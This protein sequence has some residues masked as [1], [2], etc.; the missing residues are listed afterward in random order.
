MAADG[1]GAVLDLSSLT[2]FT[3]NETSS[4]ADTLTVLAENSGKVDMSSV[5]NLSHE[6]PIANQARPS[7]GEVDLSSLQSVTG[8]TF[9]TVDAEST[10]KLGNFTVTGNTTFNINDATSIVQVAGSLLLDAP[11]V[12]NVA[13]AG[14]VSIGGNFSFASQD[15]TTFNM[16]DG[17]L[18]MVGAGTFGS[19][20]LPRSGR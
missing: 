1:F 9:F 20:Q 5:T 14:G 13:T 4:F 15:E 17:I 6:R 18:K 16:E 7:M 12:F 19:P 10:L 8:A 2:T 3:A 11:A